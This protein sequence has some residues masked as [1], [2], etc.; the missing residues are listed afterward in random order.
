MKFN[1]FKEER[2]R[3][4]STECREGRY[5]INCSQQCPGHCIKETTCNHVTGQCDKGC[6]AEW[7]GTFCYKGYTRTY[8]KELVI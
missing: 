7:T 1:H 4:I 6:E 3:F 5:G 8:F 2:M